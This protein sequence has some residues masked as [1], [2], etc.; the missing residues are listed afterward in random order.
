MLIRGN[1]MNN[2]ALVAAISGLL[3]GGVGF[4]HKINFLQI[5]GTGLLI[6]SVVTTLTKDQDKSDPQPP[7]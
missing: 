2:Q 7:H 5:A 1:N 4:T 3:I 6:S